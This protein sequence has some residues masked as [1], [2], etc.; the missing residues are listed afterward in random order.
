MTLEPGARKRTSSTC[1]GNHKLGEKGVVV[2]TITIIITSII[3]RVVV[4]LAAVFL[5]PGH[6]CLLMGFTIF[7]RF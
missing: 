6:K 1:Q 7:T 5:M 3:I 4:L 2:I